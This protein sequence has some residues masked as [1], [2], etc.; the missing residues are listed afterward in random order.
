MIQIKETSGT[1]GF[2]YLQ[3]DDLIISQLRIDEDNIIWSFITEYELRN[4]GYGS[5]LLKYICEK[6]QNESLSLFCL[7]EKIEYY[8]KFN[9]TIVEIPITDNGW[10]KM[11]RYPKQMMH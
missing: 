8:E 5:Q 3:D 4:K 11:C 9:F 10:Y 6:F 2:Y 1:Y 7:K